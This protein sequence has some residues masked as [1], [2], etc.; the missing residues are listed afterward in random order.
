MKKYKVG[1]II[2]SLDELAEQEGIY[3]RMNGS[4]KY[5]YLHLGW[6]K[7]QQLNYIITQLCKGNYYHAI[8]LEETNEKV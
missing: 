6:V 2:T 3:W 7:A 8:K 4:K 1:E 5:K